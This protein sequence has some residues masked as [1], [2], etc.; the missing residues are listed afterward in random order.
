MLFF[1]VRWLKFKKK[2]ERN[3]KI[4]TNYIYL[5]TSTGVLVVVSKVHKRIKINI[6]RVLCVLMIQ[7][8]AFR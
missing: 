4:L 5:V 8:N 1:R 6:V 2:I 3:Y 7:T